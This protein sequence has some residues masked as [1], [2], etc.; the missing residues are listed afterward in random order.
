MR[1]D[2]WPAVLNLNTRALTVVP[3]CAVALFETV[4]RLVIEVYYIQS[5]CFG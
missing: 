5:I 1:T 4:Y 3:N 2:F